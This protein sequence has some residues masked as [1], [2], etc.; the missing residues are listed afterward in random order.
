M[1]PKEEWKD[2]EDTV[3]MDERE[4]NITVACSCEHP[5]ESG[6]TKR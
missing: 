3:P 1:H 6:K 4:E 5:Q 2:M